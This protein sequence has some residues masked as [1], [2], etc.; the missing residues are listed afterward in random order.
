MIELM[1]AFVGVGCLDARWQSCSMPVLAKVAWL[2]YSRAV[3]RLFW[4]RLLDCLI[5]ELLQA[6]VGVGC[7]IARTRI[8]VSSLKDKY[9]FGANL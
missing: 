5:A 1:R 7:L 6:C 2:F 4:R 9:K 8:G 3:S